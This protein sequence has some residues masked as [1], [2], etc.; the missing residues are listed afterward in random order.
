M[1]Y[2]SYLLQLSEDTGSVSSLG[3][4]PNVSLGVVTP[5]WRKALGKHFSDFTDKLKQG[6]RPSCTS[7]HPGHP[8]SCFAPSG[9]PQ[10]NI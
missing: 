5:P 1:S 7:P 6:Q 2:A 8:R 3:A 9:R 10:G 4:A